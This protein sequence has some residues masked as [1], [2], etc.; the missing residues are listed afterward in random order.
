MHCGH[1]R[2]CAL[3]R[4]CCDD[5][6]RCN[7]GQLNACELEN[8]TL[9]ATL[10]DA[11][12]RIAALDQARRLSEQQ[13]QVATGAAEEQQGQAC[14]LQEDLSVLRDQAHTLCCDLTH[15]VCY[16]Y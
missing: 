16:T 14:R 9:K 3:Q 13:A 10:Q 12:M 1:G 2:I 5:C 7:A 11:N 4:V 15:C 8:H 6:P